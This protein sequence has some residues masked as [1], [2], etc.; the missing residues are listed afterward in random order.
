VLPVQVGPVT[1]LRA[2]PLA[3]LQIVGYRADD[4]Q[5]GFAVLSAADDAAQRVRS[6]PEPLPPSPPI[7]FAYVMAIGRQIDSTELSVE[8]QKAVVDQLRRALEDETDASV[9]RDVLAMLR[10]LDSKPFTTKRT[11]QGIAALLLVHDSPRDQGGSPPP[12]AGATAATAATAAPGEPGAASAGAPAAGATAPAAGGTGVA[13]PATPEPDPRDWF[14]ERLEQVQRQ[15]QSAAQRLDPDPAPWRPAADAAGE[16]RRSFG[17]TA[18]TG[19]QPQQRPSYFVPPPQT[20]GYTGPGPQ[21]QHQQ[22]QGWPTGPVPQPPPPPPPNYWAMSVV[23]FLL[24]LL[25]GGIAMYFSYQVGQRYRAADPDGA[26]RA[27]GRAKAW[28]IVGIVI[29]GLFWIASLSATG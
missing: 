11:Q 17:A 20:G 4:A 12:P 7:P 21:H 6:L 9:R 5:S 14:A 22:P 15:R 18:P 10:N 19:P 28:G 16:W 1:S 26:R 8:E 27:S 24:S 29:G 3:E 13:G 25:F 2:N 23:A